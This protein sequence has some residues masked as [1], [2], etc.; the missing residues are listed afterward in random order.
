MAFSLLQIMGLG[1]YH[2][3]QDKAGFTRMSRL[4][5]IAVLPSSRVDEIK[6]LQHEVERKCS[7]GYTPLALAIYKKGTNVDNIRAMLMLGADPNTGK[8]WAGLVLHHAAKAGRADVVKLLLANG[9]DP[10]SRKTNNSNPVL[11]SAV[12]VE[13]TKYLIA[14]GADVNKR[15]FCGWSTLHFVPV[16]GREQLKLAK[17]LLANGFSTEFDHVK[18]KREEDLDPY[19]LRPLSETAMIGEDVRNFFK[20]YEENPKSVMATISHLTLKESDLKEIREEIYK[21]SRHFYFTQNPS[22][23]NPAFCFDVRVDRIPDDN[24]FCFQGSSDEDE[25]DSDDDAE[26]AD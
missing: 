1:G 2:S 16:D 6:N 17:F 19:A 18:H 24:D 21:C 5:E 25:E 12:N 13:I 22:F 11:K 26:D 3:I 8:G 14:C 9:A 10:N 15:N 23:G 20:R 7:G 4:H